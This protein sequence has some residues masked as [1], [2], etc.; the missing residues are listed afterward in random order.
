MPSLALP[1]E[2]SLCLRFPSVHSSSHMLLGLLCLDCSFY[3]ASGLPAAPGAWD[4]TQ[5]PGL[6]GLSRTQSIPLTD[7]QLLGGSQFCFQGLLTRP[8]PV[9]RVLPGEQPLSSLL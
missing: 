6:T 2:V 9:P 8:W 7:M 3:R 5:G 4:P 1:A